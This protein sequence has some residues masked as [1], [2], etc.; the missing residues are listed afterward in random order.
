MYEVDYMME[1]L[2][3]MFDKPTKFCA[4]YKQRSEYN[5]KFMRWESLAMALESQ[6]RSYRII[7]YCIDVFA[8][9]R[10]CSATIKIIDFSLGLAYALLSRFK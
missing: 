2:L 9:M 5:S 4:D 10:K 1:Y 3:E 6:S 7:L 8:E